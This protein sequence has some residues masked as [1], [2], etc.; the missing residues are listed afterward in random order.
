MILITAASVLENMDTPADQ[1]ERDTFTGSKAETGI[2][3]GL[4]GPT[5]ASPRPITVTVA[6]GCGIQMT[7][8]SITIRIIQAGISPTTSDWERTVT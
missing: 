4:V 3:F 1:S 7:S 5:S 2:A 8:S 6:I